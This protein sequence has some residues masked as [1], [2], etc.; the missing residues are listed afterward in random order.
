MFGDLTE[1]QKSKTVVRHLETSIRKEKKQ[2]V[3]PRI[4]RYSSFRAYCPYQQH[5]EPAHITKRLPIE[6]C[7]SLILTAENFIKQCCTS[8][9]SRKSI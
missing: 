8:P 2:G 7:R 3:Q 4:P 6:S 1:I 5:H 9:L